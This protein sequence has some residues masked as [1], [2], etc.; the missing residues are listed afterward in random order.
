MVFKKLQQYKE[1]EAVVEY[2][3]AKVQ[4]EVVDQPEVTDEKN[5]ELLLHFEQQFTTEINDSQLL[6]DLIKNEASLSDFGANTA[7]L[8]NE[9]GQ[10]S[11]DLTGYSTS[12]MAIVEETTA[13]LDEVTSA[14]ANSTSILEDLSQ[15]SEQLTELTQQNTNELAEMQNIG[16]D[17]IENTED[18]NN[19]IIA[20]SE[21]PENVADI[22][23]AVGNIAKQTNLLALNANIEAARA[24]DAGRGFAVV[25]D[26]IRNLAEDTQAKLAEMEAFTSIIKRSTEDVTQS[27]SIT[28]NSMGLMSEKIGQ[29]NDSFERSLADLQMTMNGVMDISSMMEEVN[30]STTEVNQAMVSVS[31]DAENMNKMVDRVYDNAYRAMQQSQKI[32]EI[33]NNMSSV[34]TQLLRGMNKGDSAISNDD[35]VG[36]LEEA[37]VAHKNWLEKLSN[38]VKTGEVEPIQADGD[39]CEFGHFYNSFDIPEGE[40][41]KDW[42]SVGSIHLELHAKA[43]EI[44][45]AIENNNKSKIQNLHT[46]AQEDST[47]LIKI[48]KTII[49]KINQMTETNQSVFS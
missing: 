45:Q 49:Q 38:I 31:E 14:I 37:L 12:N 42:D 27:V 24:G 18:M 16:H 28:R 30:A 46:K 23:E 9:M 7:F 34:T 33:D 21:V 47:Q 11:M 39:R 10:L 35:L 29:V 13:G 44:I 8:A 6:L 32:E 5:K 3:Y 2:L 19:K 36:I 43:Q 17:V 25:A 15:K 22:V 26:E 1:F 4:G 48:F 20:L 41:K 40:I